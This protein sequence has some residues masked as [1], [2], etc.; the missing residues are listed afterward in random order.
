MAFILVLAVY[1]ASA[2]LRQW[3]D[4]N[5]VMHFSNRKELPAGVSVDRSMEEKESRSDTRL[6]PHTAPEDS[7]HTDQPGKKSSAS[8]NSSDMPSADIRKE[9]RH[10]EARLKAL[11][12]RI[13]T[14]RRYVK[15]HGKT[16]I[17]QIKRLESEIAILKKGGAANAAE[18][19]QRQVEK[20]AAQKRL[21]N[22][23]LRT[24]KGVGETIRE[25]KKIEAE[26]K[27]LRKRL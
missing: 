8:L 27:M 22:E 3:T 14:Q 20:E 19:K 17:Q 9:I 10:K 24:R 7:P 12:E 21:F 11:F 23:N 6:A 4:E 18:I 26:I 5:G 16:D 2:E 25:Y 1:P 15:R 13:Y